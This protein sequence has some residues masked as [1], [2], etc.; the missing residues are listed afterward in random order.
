M[1]LPDHDRDPQLHGKVPML[2]ALTVSAMVAVAFVHRGLE[3]LAPS[4]VLLTRVPQN[5]GSG[6]A[7]VVL[8]MF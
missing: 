4:N 3:S 6:H 1:W 8:L 2:I 5:R 7:G